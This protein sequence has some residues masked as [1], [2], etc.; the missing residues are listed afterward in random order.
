MLRLLHFAPSQLNPSSTQLN[1]ACMGPRGH[2]LTNN[3]GHGQLGRA[4]SAETIYYHLLEN[5]MLPVMIFVN[6]V[7]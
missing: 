3:V 2:S 1:F 7:I 6:S 5:H 4:N